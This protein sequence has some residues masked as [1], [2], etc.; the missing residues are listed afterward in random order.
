MIAALFFLGGWLG[1]SFLPP[2]IWLII[3]WAA[4]VFLFTWSWATFPRYRYDQ[5]MNISW[6]I[7]LPIAIINILWTGFAVQ[8]GLP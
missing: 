5:L 6:K 4:F 7:L 3:K 2:F 8:I 1:P